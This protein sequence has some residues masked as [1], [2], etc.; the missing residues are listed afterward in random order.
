MTIV[1]YDGKQMVA[2]TL[3]SH[4]NR[5]MLGDT[6][7]I[8]KFKNLVIG[9][10]G[11]TATI[12]AAFRCMD[13]IV[14]DT[15]FDEL[16]ATDCVHSLNEHLKYCK[17]DGKDRSASFLI[18]DMGKPQSVIQYCSDTGL[19][20]EVPAPFAIGSGDRYAYGALACGADAILAAI[21]ATRCDRSCGG[22]LLVYS[23]EESMRKHAYRI[24]EAVTDEQLIDVMQV[25]PP[26][27]ITKNFEVLPYGYNTTLTPKVKSKK[28]DRSKT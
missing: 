16:D 5:N 10:A 3:Q 23:T 9:A 21:V 20:A 24:L 22:A 25:T 6:V 11:L 15:K 26:M 17:L 2:D 28:S 7:K 1:V 12:Q 13:S 8:C 19:G 27:D 4:G 18:V 14:T